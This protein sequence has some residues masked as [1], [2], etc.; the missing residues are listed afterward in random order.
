MIDWDEEVIGPLIGVF[1]EMIQYTP[2][3]GSPVSVTGI[4]DDAFAKE[5]LFDDATTGVTEVSAVLGV[6]VSQFPSP[7]AQNDQLQVIRTGSRFVV[8]EVRVDGHGAAKL[9]LSR[10][11]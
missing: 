9:L 2:A 4:F 5:V 11:E 6:Q 3:G 10:M 8:R 1:G 7:P